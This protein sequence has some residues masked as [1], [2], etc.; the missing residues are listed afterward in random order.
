MKSGAISS[1]VLLLSMGSAFSQVQSTFKGPVALKVWQHWQQSW[2]VENNSSSYLFELERGISADK[3]PYVKLQLKSVL[4]NL[5]ARLQCESYVPRDMW[6]MKL[7]NSE[8]LSVAETPLGEETKKVFYF[9]STPC[10]DEVSKRIVR[11]ISF[12]VLNFNGETVFDFSLEPMYVRSKNQNYWDNKIP[13][14]SAHAG[15]GDISVSNWISDSNDPQVDT[16]GNIRVNPTLSFVDLNRMKKRSSIGLHRHERNQEA[17]L[18]V[19]GEAV[20][21]VGL[22]PEE[23]NSRALVKR[24]WSLAPNDVKE[25]E[26]FSTF[27]GWIESRTLKAGELSVIVPNPNSKDT[28]YFH[29]IDATEDT[30]FFTMGT[31]N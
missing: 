26:E 20:M 17:Y 2:N 23:S 4:N 5:E 6:S 9:D 1:F 25:V 28:V 21:H 7:E 13:A 22:S 24:A 19:E 15:S 14:Y 3:K 29:G 11:R 12:K 30:V 16:W 31:K 18:I 10:V 27:G 8:T